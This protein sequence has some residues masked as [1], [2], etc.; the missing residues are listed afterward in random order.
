MRQVGVYEEL[1]KEREG[2]GGMRLLAEVEAGLGKDA[3]EVLGTL[4]EG[5]VELGVLPSEGG[6]VEGEITMALMG[7]SVEVFELEALLQEVKEVRRGFERQL[8]VLHAGG[9]IREHEDETEGN[10][11]NLRQE[12]LQYTTQT[13]HLALKLAEYQDRTEVLSR[14]PR[15]A[16]S[17]E[18]VKQR[19]RE[20]QVQRDAVR[21]LE[22]RLKAYHG[23]PP[24]IEASR[25][26]V[27]RA[28][29][30]LDAL[31]RRREELFEEMGRS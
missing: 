26:E 31:R 1:E 12:T 23:L 30:D 11:T 22:E 18:V 20:L 8:E 7:L 9:G 29:S 2:D 15:P 3:R 24:D 28:Q 6:D 17:L 14:E 27:K 19:E 21:Q 4:A 5:A 10:G 16:V 25:A 13:K